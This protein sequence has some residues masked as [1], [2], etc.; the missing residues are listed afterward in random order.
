VISAVDRVAR[1][2]NK[3][4]FAVAFFVLGFMTTIGEMSVAFNST[5]KGVPQVSAGNLIGASIVIFLLIIPLLA[6]F[7]KGIALSNVLTTGNLLLTLGII[8]LPAIIT[9]DGMVLPQEGMLILLLY[10]TLI[11]RLRKKHS[12]EKTVEE[13][14]ADVREELTH[15]RRATLIDLLHVT[16]AAV[17]IFLAGNILVEESVFFTTL[18][19][20]PV[21]I[22]GLL[23]LSIGTNIPELII[24]IRSVLSGHAD[25]AFG[26]YLGSGAANSLLFGFLALFNGT[27]FVHQGEFLISFIVLFFGLILFF[28]FA[29][30]HGELSRKEGI[31]MCALYTCFLIAQIALVAG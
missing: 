12:F 4:G 2:Y 11:Y 16:V 26:D 13:T 21:S 20:V 9:L 14:V 6:I 29:R 1:R 10:A 5:I 27:F 22:A 25:I 18:W 23:V 7:S 8:V 17:I 19:G 15:K 3:P 30:S 31:V 28:V 24:A